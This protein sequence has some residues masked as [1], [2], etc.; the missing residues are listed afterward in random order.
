MEI[1][2]T[3]VT[4]AILAIVANPESRA[5]PTAISE[6]IA[7]RMEVA[8]RVFLPILCKNY[9]VNHISSVSEGLYITSMRKIGGKVI[10]TFMTV[11][12][13]EIWA[14]S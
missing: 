2:I 10:R 3:N 14:P 5:N 4:I 1:H 6:S 11:M 8:R 9:R 7:P 13:R 12:L